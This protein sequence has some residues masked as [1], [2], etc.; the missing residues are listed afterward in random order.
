MGKTNTNKYGD[1]MTLDYLVRHAL[2]IGFGKIFFILQK[3]PGSLGN[4]NLFC[5][6]FERKLVLRSIFAHSIWKNRIFDLFY[7]QYGRKCA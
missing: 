1:L 2:S 6:Q 3:I 7:I 4:F 5:I